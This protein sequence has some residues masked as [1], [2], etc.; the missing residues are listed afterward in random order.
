[1]RRCFV[2]IEVG[3]DRYE[4]F[5]PVQDVRRFAALALHVDGEDRVLREERP[6]PFGVPPVGAVCVRV[7]ELSESEAVRGFSRSQF[8]VLSHRWKLLRVG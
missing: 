5:P 4:R 3:E 6:L 1:M 2:A 8:G 7:E